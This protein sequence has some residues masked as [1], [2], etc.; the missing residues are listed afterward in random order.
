MG[1]RYLEILEI[2]AKVSRWKSTT[3][4]IVVFIFILVE[5]FFDTISGLKYVFIFNL[6]SAAEFEKPYE[7]DDFVG[8]LSIA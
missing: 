5:Q 3:L 8:D 4:F 6:I 1:F 7:C 2:D